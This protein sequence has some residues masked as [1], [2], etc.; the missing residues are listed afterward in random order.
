MKNRCINKNVESWYLHESS[1]MDKSKDDF[2]N[3]IGIV[4]EV[5]DEGYYKV[6][7]N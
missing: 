5:Q 6:G 4:V 1:Y 3:I 2:F 7:R